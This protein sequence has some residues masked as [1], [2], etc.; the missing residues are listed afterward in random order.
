MTRLRA[1]S[2]VIGFVLVFSLIVASTGIVYVTGFSALE[3]SRT[4][5]QLN[6]VERAFDI[7]DDNMRDLS[8]RGAPTRSTEVDLAGGALRLG[9]SVNLTVEAENVTSGDT[10]TIT[11]S[12][13]PI[14][15]EKDDRQVVYVYGATLRQNGDDSVMVA[16]PEWVVGERRSLFPLLVTQAAAG[17]TAVGGQTTVLVRARA[18]SRGIRSST[19]ASDSSTELTVTVESQRAEAWGQF[20]ERRGFT[21]V[22]GDPADG[23]VTYRTTTDG[24][25]IQLT[26]TAV[27]FDL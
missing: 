6:N 2:E 15:Y 19:L 12:S 7:L 9:E 24:A 21:A 27:N 25:V 14:V 22:D 10:T 1:Q 26:T 18:D 17:R 4:A 11:T 20:F 23:D 8:R 5:E 13:R 16:D 3:D